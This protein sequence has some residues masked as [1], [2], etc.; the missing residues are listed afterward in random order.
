MRKGKWIDLAQLES[1]PVKNSVGAGLDSSSSVSFS[2]TTLNTINTLDDE[3]DTHDTDFNICFI[4]LQ[5]VVRVLW[6]TAHNSKKSPNPTTP[7]SLKRIKN[8]LTSLNTWRIG[9][10]ELTLWR[11]KCQKTQNFKEALSCDEGTESRA[12]GVWH[13]MQSS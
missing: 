13:P 5:S 1:D 7:S 3:D 9:S 6:F 8:S 11:S 2:K 4:L 12:S 10:W